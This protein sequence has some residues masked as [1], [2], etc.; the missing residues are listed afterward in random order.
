V[1]ALIASSC[2]HVATEVASHTQRSPSPTLTRYTLRVMITSDTAR[3]TSPLLG[4][5]VCAVLAGGLLMAASNVDTGCRDARLA[6][7]S[8]FVVEALLAGGALIFSVLAIR[9]N[10]RWWPLL[11]LL[12]VASGAALLMALLLGLFA[13]VVPP[14]IDGACTDG[15]AGGAI[16]PL[17]ADSMITT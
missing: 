4:W 13:A 7:A 5:L 1:S 17:G 12:T 10:Q 2:V 16:P 11:C 14:D 3:R 15:T 9:R 6:W 8:F